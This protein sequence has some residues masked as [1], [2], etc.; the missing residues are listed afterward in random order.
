MH[1]IDALHVAEL[2]S[3]AF[4]LAI[5]TGLFPDVVEAS[6]KSGND[7]VAASELEILH[8][9]LIVVTAVLR[10]ARCGVDLFASEL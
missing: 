4:F 6:S 2:Q 9:V 7:I 3:L 1:T 10:L 5:S 8:L